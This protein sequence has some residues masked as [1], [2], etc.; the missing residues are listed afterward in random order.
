MFQK[1]LGLQGAPLSWFVKFYLSFCNFNLSSYYADKFQKH[2][3]M[4]FHMSFVSSQG[5]TPK[6]KTQKDIRLKTRTFYFGKNKFSSYVG[7]RS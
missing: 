7:S 5:G 1:L 6:K 3:H 2:L 4:Y